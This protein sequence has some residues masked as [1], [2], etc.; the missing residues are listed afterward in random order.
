MYVNINSEA[1]FYED[2]RDIFVF[3]KF[4]WEVKKKYENVE[5]GWLQF[6]LLAE[7]KKSSYLH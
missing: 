1:V 7:E 3:P 6:W 4:Q 2:F 5:D